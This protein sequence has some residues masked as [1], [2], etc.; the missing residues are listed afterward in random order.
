MEDI[1]RKKKCC[2]GRIFVLMVVFIGIEAYLITYVV[3]GGG[4]GD[5][6]RGREGE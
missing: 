6:I 5:K 1:F 4:H 3:R 2:N